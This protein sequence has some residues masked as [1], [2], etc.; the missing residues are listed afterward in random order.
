MEY[1]EPIHTLLI[2]H[3]NGQSAG[4][5]TYVQYT[6]QTGVSRQCV[7]CMD[8]GCGQVLEGGTCTVHT[9]H[10]VSHSFGSSSVCASDAR[11]LNIYVENRGIVMSAHG[12]IETKQLE[13]EDKQ[14]ELPKFYS[15]TGQ[16][17]LC[18]YISL[19]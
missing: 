11:Q 18:R 15:Y 10:T 5:A 19:Q 7:R 12:E 2:K 4:G 8:A 14:I 17:A 6:Q 13:I 16:Y 9:I 1:L 3:I